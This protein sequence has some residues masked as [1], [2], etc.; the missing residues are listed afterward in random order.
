M[1][2]QALRPPE[3]YVADTGTAKGRGVF[4]VRAF[5]AGEL[6]ETSPVV[7]CGSKRA[8]IPMALRRY[9]F[10]WGSL[11]QVE[12]SCAMVLGYG[13]MYNH[14][15]PASLRFEAGRQD[16]TLHFLAVRDIAAHEE[17]TINYNAMAGEHESIVDHWFT[18][19]GIQR[20]P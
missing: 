18:A 4:A 20:L 2:A 3:I 14:A 1:P 6:V 10:D 5:A 19:M 8:T 17:L 15:N 13:S 9:L 7:L 12:Q 11:A 16:L